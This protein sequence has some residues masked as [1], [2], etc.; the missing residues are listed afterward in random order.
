[1]INCN[2]FLKYLYLYNK[3]VK[4]FS[5]TVFVARVAYVWH[6]T[7]LLQQKRR[8]KIIIYKFAFTEN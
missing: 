6:A 5:E 7:L 1:M 3:F 2:F 4:L 8:T